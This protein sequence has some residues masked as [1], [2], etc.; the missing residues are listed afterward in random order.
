LLATTQDSVDEIA[1]AV[2]YE[3]AS[4]LRTL[5]RRK[6]HTRIRDLRTRV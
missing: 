3:D 5:L 2:G 6:Q 4:T 1:A